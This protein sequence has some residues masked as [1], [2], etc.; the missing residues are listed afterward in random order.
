MHCIT[1]TRRCFAF[2]MLVN[3]SDAAA[4]NAGRVIGHE[5]GDIFLDNVGCTGNETNLDDCIHNGVGV[6]NCYHGQD[7]GVTCL[8]GV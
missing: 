5:R 7:A 2:I 3:L 1:H 8:Q 6:H 4:I